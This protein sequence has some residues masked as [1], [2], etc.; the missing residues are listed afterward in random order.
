LS[1]PGDVFL[2]RLVDKESTEVVEKEA[3]RIARDWL[4]S[5]ASWKSAS[6]RQMPTRV[7]ILSFASEL[8]ISPAIV[9][10][11]IQKEAE[12]Y[13]LFTD[14]VGQGSIRSKFLAE[15]S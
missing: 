14:M 8:G 7:G 11:R 3:N 6:V 15:R 4:I 2:D 12:N 5:R 1:N 13:A 10:G 9:A